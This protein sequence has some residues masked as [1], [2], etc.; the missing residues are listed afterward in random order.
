MNVRNLE[1]KK[2]AFTDQ[3]TKIYN[4]RQL[5]GALENVLTYSQEGRS[6]GILFIDI[7]HFKNIN[8]TYGHDI[9]DMVLLEV[10]NQIRSLM[11]D[12]HIF[13][14]WGGEEFIYLVPDVDEKS[15]GNFGEKVRKIIENKKF[16]T[17][18]HIT[19]SVG[20]TLVNS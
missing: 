6:Y 18:N 3:L 5:E 13:G 8:D 12:D 17:V 15:L 10:V 1:L 14:R 20:V 2:I 9:G 16:S 7:D 4:R 11:E 19:V